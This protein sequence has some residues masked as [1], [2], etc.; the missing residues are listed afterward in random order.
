MVDKCRAK[1]AEQA[2]LL[3]SIKEDWWWPTSIDV[4]TLDQA[5]W[6]KCVLGQNWGNFASGMN[7]IFGGERPPCSGI[8]FSGGNYDHTDQAY[9]WKADEETE[10]WKEQIQVRRE[11]RPVAVDQS[12]S[13]ANAFMDQVLTPVPAEPDLW[14]VNQSEYSKILLSDG[15]YV[16]VPSEWLDTATVSAISSGRKVVEWNFEWESRS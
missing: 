8:G 15:R 13:S 7:A 10:A 4:D 1:V 14:V 9:Q 12:T 3:D 16:I 11:T 6:S 2:Q 5:D